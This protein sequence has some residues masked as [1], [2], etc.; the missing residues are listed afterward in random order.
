MRLRADRHAGTP[1]RECR[2][3]GAEQW[4]WDDVGGFHRTREGL[5]AP[6]VQVH[7]TPVMFHEEGI[8]PVTD[9]AFMFGA[10]LV[11]CA[12]HHDRGEGGGSDP[13]RP[14]TGLMCGLAAPA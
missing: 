11:A 14:G 2:A 6:D 12:H 9:H 1:L 5:D 10:A 7:A 3:A 4:G 8:S 13:R